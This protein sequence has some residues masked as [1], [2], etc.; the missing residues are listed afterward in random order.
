MGQQAWERA[1]SPQIGAVD[2]ISERRRL[3][4]GQRKRKSMKHLDNSQYP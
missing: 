3:P 1:L 4:S 2:S